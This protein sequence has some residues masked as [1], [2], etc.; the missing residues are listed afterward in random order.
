MIQCESYCHWFDWLDG[1]VFV[2]LVC[3]FLFSGLVE[4]LKIIKQNLTNARLSSFRCCAKINEEPDEKI[5]P[6][7]EHL[8]QKV[9]VPQ[10]N[11]LYCGQ[12]TFL[13]QSIL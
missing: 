9:S 8:S 11:S 12:A 3:F 7:C 13:Q 5:C 4:L 10:K 6:S 1:F 2:F